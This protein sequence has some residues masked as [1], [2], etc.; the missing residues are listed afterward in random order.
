MQAGE[1]GTGSVLHACQYEPGTQLEFRLKRKSLHAR[2][3]ERILAEQVPI[4]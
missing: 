2:L 3:K 4:I 1:E